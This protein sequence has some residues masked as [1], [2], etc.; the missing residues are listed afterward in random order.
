M[1]DFCDANC[2]VTFTKS[3][4]KMY[5]PHGTI[6]MQDLREKYGANMWQFNLSS[7]ATTNYTIAA[8]TTNLPNVIPI[9]NN[10]FPHSTGK[11]KTNTPT[12]QHATT[13]IEVKSI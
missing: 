11:S 5:N 12:R 3:D 8:P 2:S 7:A 6:T 1:G 10:I 4:F 13:P 9:E